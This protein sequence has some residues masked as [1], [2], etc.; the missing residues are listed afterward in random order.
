[1]PLAGGL[2][3]GFQC[4][5]QTFYRESWPARHPAIELLVPLDVSLSPSLRP[6][7]FLWACSAVF[8]HTPFPGSSSSFFDNAFRLPPPFLV[9]LL[10]SVTIA[11]HP[12]EPYRLDLVLS[13]R[14][15]QKLSSAP[16]GPVWTGIFRFVLSLFWMMSRRR[17]AAQ[18]FVFQ[19]PLLPFRF[20]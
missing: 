15:P 4:Q 11:L 20:L 17:L 19:V 7:H 14:S 16:N 13:L 5:R 9:L 1:V 3:E 8:P 18:P 6:R 2:F 12:K 10:P